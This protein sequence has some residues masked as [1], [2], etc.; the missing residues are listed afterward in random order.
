LLA[1]EAGMRA[2]AVAVGSALWAV[3]LACSCGG[4]DDGSGSGVGVPADTLLTELTDAEVQ[5]LCRYRERAYKDSLPAQDAYCTA[6]GAD[7]ATSTAECEQ[8]KQECIEGGQYTSDVEED[9]D[10]ERETADDLVEAD[11]ECS[12]TV[13]DLEACIEARIRAGSDYAA[14]VSCD[15]TSTFE[16]GDDP[17]EC[18]TLFGA[19]PDLG[20]L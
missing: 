14:T 20:G 18:A 6:F 3:C 5:D 4:D 17:V 11:G 13:G 8:W 16:D 15:D 19:C 9:W 7:G 10:C 2:R 12:A 1:R